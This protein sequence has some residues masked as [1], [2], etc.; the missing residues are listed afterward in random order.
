MLEKLSNFT[1]GIAGCGGLGSNCAVSLAR[2]GIGKLILIDFDII[3]ESN[4]NRQYFFRDQLGLKKCNALKDNIERIT[5]QTSL[6][7]IDQKLTPE[8][9]VNLFSECDIIVEAFDKDDQK[10]MLLE[11]VIEMMP[12]KYVVSGS[13]LAG[14]GNNNTLK[15][16]QF[17]HIFICG[18]FETE[19]CDELPPLA[20]RVCTVANMQAN[21]VVEIIMNLL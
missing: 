1:I 16:V 17:D 21:Q 11:T 19:V 18:D 2:I 4:L 14:W 13:G 10:Q 8:S 12:D 15:T 7:A 5:H 9:I 20:P 3:V 6:E